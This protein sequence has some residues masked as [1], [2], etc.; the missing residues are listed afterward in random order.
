MEG[1]GVVPNDQFETWTAL[2]VVCCCVLYYLFIFAFYVSV[3]P[4]QTVTER[5]EA[6]RRDGGVFAWYV[7]KWANNQASIDHPQPAQH[8]KKK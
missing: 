3:A 7:A 5:M 6:M 8:E 2:I 1:F 4:S